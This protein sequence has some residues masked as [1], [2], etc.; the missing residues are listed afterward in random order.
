[1][2]A[3]GGLLGLSGVAL[4]SVELGIAMSAVMLGAL[5][6][7]SIRLPL[8]AALLVVGFFAVFHGHA[9]GTEMTPGQS[10]ILYS[11]GFVIATGLLLTAAL[12]V[13]L[14]AAWTRIALRV[15]GSWI[16]AVGMLM[17]GWLLKGAGWLRPVPAN[18]P[19]EK[20]LT[21]EDERE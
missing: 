7:G 21:R 11:L 3:F 15:G 9:H 12:A 19:S 8:A 5:I 6:L 13:S 2:M 1:M 4:P 20:R 16:A 10:A 18:H 14:R 17:L